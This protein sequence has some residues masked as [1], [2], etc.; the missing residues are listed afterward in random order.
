MPKTE[1]IASTDITYRGY[2]SGDAPQILGLYNSVF[3][4]PR[5]IS[6]WEWEYAD[7]PI[8]RRDILLAFAGERLIGHVGGIPMVFQH[9]EKAITTTRL[10]HAVVHPDF[11]R[12]SP[13][14]KTLAQENS[15]TASNFRRRSVFGESLSQLTEHLSRSGVGFVFAFPNKNSLPRISR[16]EGYFHLVDIFRWV[17]S[18]SIAAP[19]PTGVTIEISEAT[20]FDDTDIQCAERLLAPFAIFNRRDLNYLRWRYHPAS[21]KRYALARVWRDGTLAGWAVAKPFLPERSIDLAECFLP[22]EKMLLASLLGAL[23]ENFRGA[24]ADHFSVW[25]MEHYPLHQCLL[26]LG[27]TAD[28]RPTHMMIATLSN[29]CSLHSREPDAYYLSMGDSDV[30]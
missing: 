2:R 1:P 29:R 23:T 28:P 19:T 30:Y 24:A 11:Y 7:N 22:P 14:T 16:T 20:H 17:R 26:D 4:T 8:D 27:F 12:R 21:G 15:G 13:F 3:A 5:T 25:S 18:V 9:E 6:Q 10:Q